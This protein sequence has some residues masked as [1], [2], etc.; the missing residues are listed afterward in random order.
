MDEVGNGKE[1][2]ISSLGSITDRKMSFVG[3]TLQMFRQLCVLAGCDYLSSIPGLGI[4]K[5]HALMKQ[6]KS[7]ER[8]SFWFFLQQVDNT[9]SLQI[10]SY[11]HRSKQ[12]PIPVGYEEAFKKA[13]LTFLH[14]RV[15]DNSK[16]EIVHLNPLPEELKEVEMDFLGPYLFNTFFCFLFSTL[17]YFTILKDIPPDVGIQIAVGNMDP[18]NRV[19]FETN[20]TYDEPIETQ[21]VSTGLNSV[22]CKSEFPKPT[23]Y[24]L[25]WPFISG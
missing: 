16:N 2:K 25:E 6:Y 14:Q 19:F 10:I 18:I 15:F 13:E 11:L 17:F 7:I 20:F 9:F 1:I 21:Q 3:F 4:K 8:V 24:Y 23:S 22:N 5:A 12:Y